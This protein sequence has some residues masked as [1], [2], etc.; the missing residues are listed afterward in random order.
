MV[1]V[2][3]A[4]PDTQRLPREARACLGRLLGVVLSKINLE[5]R[6]QP[7]LFLSAAL[8]LV[9][10]SGLPTQRFWNPLAGCKSLISKARN[11]ACVRSV[12]GARVRLSGRSHVESV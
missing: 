10:E 3:A 2:A 9:W 7:R 5:P 12:L 6:L 11:P 8:A 4:H 1:E